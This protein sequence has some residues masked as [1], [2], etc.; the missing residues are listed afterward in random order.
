MGTT[1]SLGTGTLPSAQFPQ[2]AGQSH[3]SPFF[4]QGHPQIDT[5]GAMAT[6][7]Q[8]YLPT[9]GCGVHGVG[10]GV[11]YDGAFFFLPRCPGSRAGKWRGRKGMPVACP[12]WRPWTLSCLP[13]APQTSPCVCRCR[14]CTRLVVSEG[15][16]AAARCSAPAHL[17]SSALRPPPENC[18]QTR[19]I[20]GQL[21][22]PLPPCCTLSGG[23]PI[24][25]SPSIH[26]FI[27]LSQDCRGLPPSRQ[28][29]S[30]MPAPVAQ[31]ESFI[32]LHLEIPDLQETPST[33]GMRRAGHAMMQTHKQA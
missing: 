32:T 9:P 14:T 17:A 8:A 1:A 13:H 24:H 7:A 26:L 22:L 5:V 10:G 30:P 19:S 3:C 12:S 27:H 2:E 23:P 15:S 6:E 25:L 4:G 31:G 11:C 16:M 29:P 18:P 20:Q 28:V 33:L 21:F